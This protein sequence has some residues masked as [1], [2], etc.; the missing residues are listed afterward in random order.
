MMQ[1]KEVGKSILSVTIGARVGGVHRETSGRDSRIGA[2]KKPMQPFLV[3]GPTAREAIIF[4][5]RG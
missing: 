3:V 5:S 4:S 2:F 1:A